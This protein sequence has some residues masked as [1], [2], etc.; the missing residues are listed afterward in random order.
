[1]GAAGDGAGVGKCVKEGEMREGRG[2]ACV[3]SARRHGADGAEGEGEGRTFPSASSAPSKKSTTPSI[4]NSAPNVVS[5]TPI[6]VR[7][8]PR[9]RGSARAGG[10]VRGAHD[11]LWPSESH[12]LET[13]DHG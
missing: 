2:D 10:T 11:A 5:A 13:G 12:I 7:P 9:R 3:I 8:R 4:M 1:M 6:S